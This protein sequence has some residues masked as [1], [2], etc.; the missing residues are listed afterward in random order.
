LVSA[1][2]VGSASEKNSLQATE[3]DTE[4]NLKHREEFVAKIRTV[5]PELLIFLDESGITTSMT[6][7]YARTLG[8]KRIHESTSGGHWKIMT[9]LGA[10]SFCGMV[11]TMTIEEAT[12]ADIFLAYVEQVLCPTLKPGYVAVM[13]NLSSRKVNGVRTR[14]EKAGAEVLYIPPYS[15]DLNPIEKAWS[16]LKQ[17]LRTA[18]ASTKEALDQAIEEALKL[19]SLDNAKAWF[20]HCF[21]GLQ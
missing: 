19:I 3:R 20:K 2:E 8:G 14:I 17:L 7:L 1:A 16:K 18:K 4:A 21:D 10:M 13:G 6:R 11:A 9:I 12:D 5:A 15:P